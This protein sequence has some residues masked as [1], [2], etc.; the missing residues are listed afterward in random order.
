MMEWETLEMKDAPSPRRWHS[1]DPI[2]EK[3]NQYLLYGGYDGD[4]NKLKA[5]MHI[6]DLGKSSEIL[7]D[8]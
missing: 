7:S 1:F 5:D 3:S 4:F 6:L 8:V 2:P